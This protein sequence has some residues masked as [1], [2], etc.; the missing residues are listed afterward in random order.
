MK[1]LI[2]GFGNVFFS[3]DGFGPAVIRS[4][5]R[6][7]FGPG[8]A[9]RDFGTGGLHLALEMC[10]GYDL[11][12]IVDAV[13]RRDEPG[14][15]YAIEAQE[16]V[17]PSV[18]DAHAMDVSALLGVFDSMARGLDCKRPRV[19]VAGCV[20]QSTEEGMELTAAVRAAIPQ[21]RKLLR[22]LITQTV[23]TGARA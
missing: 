20:P 1:T 2:A 18:P 19:I 10:A 4:F 22:R 9:V 17:E 23:A 11:V 6:D 14:T 5:D 15:V 16:C 12:V 13:A 8:V 21:C 3:D 7:E